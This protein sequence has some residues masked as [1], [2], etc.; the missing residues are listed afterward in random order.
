MAHPQ[1]CTRRLQIVD[2]KTELGIRGGFNTYPHENVLGGSVG[3]RSA[4]TV[5][6][7][8]DWRRRPKHSPP[9]RR[10]ACSRPGGFLIC[11][12]VRDMC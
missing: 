7:K 5:L 2:R 10:Y 1:R 8:R 11:A 6:E 12:P 3:L 9:R 4:S